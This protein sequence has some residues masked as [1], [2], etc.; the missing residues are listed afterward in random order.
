MPYKKKS[1][2]LNQFLLFILAFFL[3]SCGNNGQ[4]P[5][6]QKEK[7]SPKN[8]DQ[9]V[10]ENIDS[11]DKR[12]IIE[13]M[14]E[15]R[16]GN[17]QRASRIFNEA[18][19]NDPTNSALHTLN[20]FAYQLMGKKGNFSS[21]DLA[22]AGYLQAK[23]FNPSNTFA[24]LQLG[25][26]KVEKRDYLGAQ[27]EFA[28]VL[29]FD[30]NNQEALYELAS[31]SYLMGD[32]ETA[33]MSIDQLLKK[34]SKK[35]D[36]LRA[37]AM[38]YAAQGDREAARRLLISYQNLEN[39]NKNKQFLE[40]RVNDWF[41]LYD[42]GNVIPVA[43]KDPPPPPPPPLPSPQ[44][45]LAAQ[46]HFEAAPYTK[47][48]T[49]EQA[50][51]DFG[52]ESSPHPPGTPSEELEEPMVVID[53]VVLRI[54]EEAF[55]SKGNNILDNFTLTIAP[56]SKYFARNA[57]TPISG[58]NIFPFNNASATLSNNTVIPGT[59]SSIF[60]NA[61]NHVS[62]VTG[63]IT[64]GTLSYA[65]NIANATREHIEIIGRPTLTSYIGK[66]S[67]FFNGSELDIAL[68]GSFGGGTV[69]KTPTG[70]TLRVTPISLQGD[71]VTLE[72]AVIDSFLEETEASIASKVQAL[73]PLVFS[74]NISNVKTT[75]RVKLGETIML[76]GT[77][78][79]SD[80]ASKSGFPVLQDIPL[81]QY[82]F[83]EEST[84]SEHQSVLYLI[85]P[86]ARKDVRKSVKEFFSNKNNFGERPTLDELE[87][88][89]PN[90]LKPEKNAIAILRN[91]TP[92]YYDYRSGDI[93]P[94]NWGTP[95]DFYYDELTE[96]SSFLWY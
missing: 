9:I 14:L 88:R 24:S 5:F 49:A 44:G 56:Y 38:I 65:L 18:L 16:K 45:S 1:Q 69:T 40:R 41:H 30:P 7:N 3:V 28:E 84:I 54:I 78:E 86:R 21:Y 52:A 13:G 61:D 17:F 89:N 36:Y 94:L 70:S 34:N 27:E 95:P 92:L 76:G 39:N 31:A 58:V 77:V 55:T 93:S 59:V 25:R 81:L 90:W 20:G 71:Y 73:T 47:F 11:E 64:F 74:I 22:E 85:T 10:A 75:I 4:K 57:G 2:P 26:V 79:R 72:V 15:L 63:G 12:E 19:H 32:I 80:I 83:S 91:L 68:T 6:V 37:G 87:R 82:F 8:F 51:K 50:H 23:K 33:T 35:S 46:A 66:P 43:A 67:E 60:P 29:L 96:I 53:G 62:L 48:P 42:T